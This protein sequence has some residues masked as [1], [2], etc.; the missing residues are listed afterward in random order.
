MVKMYGLF[1]YSWSFEKFDVDVYK[2]W[3]DGELRRPLIQMYS[4]R[5]GFELMWQKLF[6]EWHWGF[7][8]NTNDLEKSVKKFIEWCGKTLFLV[9][10]YPNLWINFGP[11]IVAGYLGAKVVFK[12]YSNGSG[13]V[14]FGASADPSEIRNWDSIET[15][16]R[17]NKDNFWWRLTLDATRIALKNS[18][19]RYIVGFTDLGGIHDILASLRGTENLVKDMY[20]NPRKV[21]EVSWRILDLWHIYYDKLYEIIKECQYG[22]SAW[23]NLWSSLRWYPI[24]CDFSAMLS[25]K[26][27]QKFVLPILEEQCRRLD[28]I[29][30]HL[31]GPGELPHVDYLLRIEKL[32]GIQW[33]PG[34]KMELEEKDCSS[35]QWI[36]LY[37]KIL[38]HKKNLVIS[39]PC[40]KVLE[41]IEKIKSIGS[42]GRIAIQTTCSNK[43][44]AR[45]IVEKLI[46]NKIIEIHN[47]T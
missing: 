25:P 41:T 11:G 43:E 36:P 27:F 16:L 10:A 4:P 6:Y 24:Q 14:W 22:T 34:A 40:N 44:Q 5:Q 39:I 37:K 13:T 9:D 31:D 23:M 32:H 28:H 2:A 21:E 42:I 20:F 7:P 19:D 35:N 15:M 33:V 18:R 45:K 30:Y 29:I 17:F 38:E 1:N 47:K 26:L 12:E 8:R 3:W 46:K